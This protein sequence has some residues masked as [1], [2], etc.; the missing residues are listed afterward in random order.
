MLENSDIKRFSF[1]SII[2]SCPW[3]V[4]NGVRNPVY[5]M[6]ATF[7]TPLIWPIYS[8]TMISRPSLPYT[9]PN[10]MDLPGYL[11]VQ[12]FCPETDLIL[13]DWLTNV[14]AVSEHY[15]LTM[16]SIL[17]RPVRACVALSHDLVVACKAEPM[18]PTPPNG[19]H[20]G[21]CCFRP[22]PISI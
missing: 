9:R 18:R 14:G 3:A 21:L 13:M 2:P 8:V 6:T 15:K 12:L 4:T 1:S 5:L 16:L 7:R 19:Y 10:T 11:F 22:L 20:H 17:I